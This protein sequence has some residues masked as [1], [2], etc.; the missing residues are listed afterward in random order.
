MGVDETL[1]HIMMECLAYMHIRK[2]YLE[3]Y[4]SILG[5]SN[6]NEVI[7]GDDNGMGYLLGLKDETPY[8]LVVISRKLITKLWARRE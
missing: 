6:F 5:I 1:H 4:K 7:S 3:G 2:E 8:H